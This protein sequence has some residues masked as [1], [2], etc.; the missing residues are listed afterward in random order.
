MA[1]IDVS[2]F[3]ERGQGLQN[4]VADIFRRVNFAD[5]LTLAIEEVPGTADDADAKNALSARLVKNI[6]NELLP[7]VRKPMKGVRVQFAEL[8]SKDVI[9]HQIPVVSSLQWVD[10]KGSQKLRAIRERPKARIAKI[11]TKED[12]FI[13]KRHSWEWDRLP[14][15]GQ[16]PK[17]R[18]T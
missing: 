15:G 7:Y 17:R 10:T 18:D 4:L 16:K 9:V 8:D 2:D 12:E 13:E 6:D 5:K 1:A 3:A 11:L 14:N